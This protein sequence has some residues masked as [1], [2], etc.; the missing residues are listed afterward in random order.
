MPWNFEGPNAFF[1]YKSLIGVINHVFITPT[2]D[3]Y[4]FGFVAEIHSGGEWGSSLN[5]NDAIGL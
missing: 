2:S 4:L 3:S 1:G 5:I